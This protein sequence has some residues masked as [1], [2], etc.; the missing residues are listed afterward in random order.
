MIAMTGP[1][2]ELKAASKQLRKS[3]WIVQD[4]QE[5]N[6]KTLYPA[7]KV[8]AWY[9]EVKPEPTTTRYDGRFKIS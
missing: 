7:P 8:G 9:M 5:I 3:G 6:T 1:R 4:F 2:E